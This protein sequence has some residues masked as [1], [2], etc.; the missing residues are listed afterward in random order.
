MKTSPPVTG[1]PAALTP[2]PYNLH[3]MIIGIKHVKQ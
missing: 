3:L 2:K 1:S